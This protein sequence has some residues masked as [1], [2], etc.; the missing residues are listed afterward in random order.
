MFRQHAGRQS[1]QGPANVNRIHDLLR[2][3]GAHN[4]TTRIQLG[5][6]AFLREYGQGLT[7]RCSGH[8]QLRCQFDLTD[9][10]ARRELAVQNH[11]ANSNDDSCVLG[12]HFACRTIAGSDCRLKVAYIDSRLAQSLAVVAS[13]HLEP[14]AGLLL[15]TFCGATPSDQTI[16]SS[17][18][19][20]SLRINGR[21]SSRIAI[22]SRSVSQRSGV[23]SG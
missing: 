22:F 8:P 13:S 17:L 1:L 3:E 23:I 7:D 15:R 10:L 21:T 18:R 16:P 2:C 20:F 6:Y 4:E 11:L 5:E 9:A 19:A 14:A 12:A